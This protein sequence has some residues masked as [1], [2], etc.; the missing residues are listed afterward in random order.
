[1]K[2]FSKAVVFVL[3]SA[4]LA[5][6]LTALASI[7]ER[8]GPEQPAGCHQET[9]RPAAPPPTSHQC[10][11]S[12]HEFA[13]VP[14]RCIEQPSLQAVSRVVPAPS[15]ELEVSACDLVQLAIAPGDPPAAPPLRV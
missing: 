12:S 8:N 5:A 7:P 13:L 4:V 11:Q 14:Q 15:P 9:G 1:M 3:L 6:P 2:F 10:C